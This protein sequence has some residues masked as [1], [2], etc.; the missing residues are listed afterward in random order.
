MWRG[1]WSA[2]AM[3]RFG[4]GAV[5]AKRES[6]ELACVSQDGECQWPA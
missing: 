2:S 4:V 6:E 3:V 5:G 1:I